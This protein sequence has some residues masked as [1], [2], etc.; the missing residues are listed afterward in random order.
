MQKALPILFLLSVAG[1]GERSDAVEDA[2]LPVC[3]DDFPMEP[4][5]AGMSKRAENGLEIRLAS[6]NPTPPRVGDNAWQIEILDEEGEGV[7][8]VALSERRFMP[9]HGHAGT[10]VVKVTEQDEE[11][12]YLLDE[13]NFF[14]PGVW[15]V[16]LI[17]PLPPLTESAGDDE[18]S[19]VFAFCIQ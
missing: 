7:D 3:A 4:Y 17:A 12:S 18:D 6:A 5:E 11:G 1:C 9:A 10:R 8:G 2:P 16:R 14:M 19:V 13:L 15:E